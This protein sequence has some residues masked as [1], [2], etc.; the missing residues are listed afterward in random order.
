MLSTNSRISLA[1]DD[2]SLSE[3]K[4]MQEREREESERCS[5][6]KWIGAV[7]GLKQ[8]ILYARWKPAV[9]FSSLLD[10]MLY[11]CSIKALFARHPNPLC[12]GAPLN[13]SM[14]FL[15]NSIS[16]EIFRSEFTPWKGASA[17]NESSGG[18]G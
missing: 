1:L 12:S 9:P 8:R 17:A 14:H 5:I 15:R 7:V 13:F 4:E 11:Y 3:R 16:A 2:G 6:P 10:Y 18:D